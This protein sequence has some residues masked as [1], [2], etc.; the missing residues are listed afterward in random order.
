MYLVLLLP[1]DVCRSVQM[2]VCRLLAS[3]IFIAALQFIAGAYLS[4]YLAPVDKML[5]KI[6]DRIMDMNDPTIAL[7]Y[8]S[9]V[10]DSLAVLW[11]G[12]SALTTARG[13]RV[14]LPF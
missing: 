2:C 10:A 12:M 5:G 6:R 13:E 4:S 9:I 14:M 1:A 3:G 8:Y 7:K 11:R